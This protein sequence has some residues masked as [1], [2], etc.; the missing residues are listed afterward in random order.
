MRTVGHGVGE[1][2]GAGLARLTG[3]A[4]P[5]RTAAGGSLV[6]EGA[7]R[8]D[9]RSAGLRWPWTAE[10][11]RP[12]IQLT[13]LLRGELVNVTDIHPATVIGSAMSDT[14][15]VDIVQPAIRKSL[16]H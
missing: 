8:Q 14:R 10:Q 1:L 4:E 6:S 12:V 7:G 2:A 11:T 15:L 5:K 13:V 16:L 9:A 3:V